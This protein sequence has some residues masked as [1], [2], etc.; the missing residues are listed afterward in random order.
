M[1]AFYYLLSFTCGLLFHFAYCQP[2]WN[3]TQILLHYDSATAKVLHLSGAFRY[4]GKNGYATLEQWQTI[5]NAVLTYAE[6]NG[7]PFAEIG[8]TELQVK[9]NDVIQATINYRS[10]AFI[11]FDTLIVIGK[12]GV[13]PALLQ[14]LLGIYP[15]E[16]FRQT[17]VNQATE[18]LKALPYLRLKGEVGVVFRFDR[19]H[20]T[21]HVEPAQVSR[22]DGIVGFLP[23]QERQGNILLTGMANLHLGNLFNSGKSLTAEWQRIRTATQSLKLAYDH[24][25]LLRTRLHAAFQLQFLK[26]DTTFFN[27]HWQAKLEYLLFAQRKSIGNLGFFVRNQTSVVT[28]ALRLPTDNH[29]QGMRFVSYGMSYRFNRVNN[30]LQPQKGWQMTLEAGI[31]NK[32]AQQRLPQGFATGELTSFIPTGKLTA[33]RLR[34]QGGLIFSR[35]L[36]LNELFRLG[37]LQSLRGFNEN[38]FFASGYLIATAEERLYFEENSFLFAFVD[39]G[40][41]QRKTLHQFL[42]DTP[43]GI[44]FG[45][46]LNTKG[47]IF[48]LTYAMG[49]SLQLKQNFSLEQSKI[50]FGYVNRF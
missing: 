34:F 7:Y 24:P 9:E 42:T 46:N 27:L 44:G 18:T 14:T 41:L 45:I 49:N 15:G 22:F 2:S 26:Q 43:L 30:P 28:T 16:P 21:L 11:R 35:Q 31:G 23:N 47:G 6:N 12:G 50:H 25:F 10:G 17:L 36:F 39:Y 33:L 48:S 37:G 1:S 19:A 5:Q 3:K 32:A 8:L 40:R 13:K 29:I 38:D 4:I 20:L